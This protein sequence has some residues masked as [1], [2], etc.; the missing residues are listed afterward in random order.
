VYEENIR[1]S[2]GYFENLLQTNKSGVV[3]LPDVLPDVFHN[4]IQWLYTG[5]FFFGIDKNPNP[6]PV[7][8]RDAYGP[9]GVLS[10][11]AYAFEAGCFLKDINYQDAAIDVLIEKIHDLV[12][13]NLFNNTLG[14]R[15]ARVIYSA[16]SDGAP[17]RRLPVDAAMSQWSENH[18]MV[19]TMQPDSG[20]PE[21]F[22]KDMVFAIVQWTGIGR[23]RQE[24]PFAEDPIST[25]EYHQ[26][27]AAGTKCYRT[28]RYI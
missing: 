12:K 13:N 23:K 27:W 4:Y 16:T 2:S 25:C 9:M 18:F 1:K 8:W 22:W 20:T 28:S 6:K 15:I 14:E 26:H 17:V 3:D 11:W 5:R 7:G 24:Y 10:S 21:A 19:A